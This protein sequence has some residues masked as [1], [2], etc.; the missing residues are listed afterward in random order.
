[1]ADNSSSAIRRL[2][3]FL[4][5]DLG[6]QG[7]VPLHAPHF[8]GREK[9]YVVDCIDST[10][11][12]SVGDYV[13]KFETEVARRS[14]CAFG[15]ATMNGTAAIHALLHALEVGR[16]DLVICPALTFVATVNAILY[17]GAQPIF[18]DSDPDTLGLSLPEVERFLQSC[19]RRADGVWHQGQ[20]VRAAMPVHIFGHVIDVVRLSQ[21]CA[22]Y[23]VTVIEDA[24]ESLGASRDGRQAGSLSIAAALSFNGNK[25]VTT[26][27]GGAIVTNDEA[28]AVRLKHL[29]TT[30]RAKSG[31]TFFHDEMGFNYR[32][33]NLN[34]ALG[35]AQMEQLD[36]FIAAKRAL[37]D[38]YEAL[39]Q[40][41]PDA[42]FVKEA[43][44]VRSNYW[45]Q[46]IMLPDL[47]TRNEALEVLQAEGIEA[48]PCWT[49]MIDLPYLKDSLRFGDLA[50]ARD[51]ESRLVNIPS[52]PAL[53]T[54]TGQG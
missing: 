5:D 33:P 10:Y 52:S 26:G 38:R 45:L 27:G 29:T 8:G 31:W 13:V 50:V 1:M 23:G 48:R 42:Q 51:I 43:A 41:C 47:D 14:G 11:V 4:R 22:E 16:G 3:S 21:I 46:A 17:T 37:A 34:A 12:S 15:V 20:R 35:L 18:L 24:A 19:E 7:R 40:G 9:D 39:F 30:A 49:L 28:L 2:V 6:Q 36:G 25:V 44:G 53:M 54:P 32:M